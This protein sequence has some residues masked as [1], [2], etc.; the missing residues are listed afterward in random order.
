MKIDMNEEHFG[1]VLP[2]PPVHTAKQNVGGNENTSTYS[3]KQPVASTSTVS[4]E[5]PPT[6]KSTISPELPVTTNTN[7]NK[8][9]ATDDS[10]SDSDFIGDVSSDMDEEKKIQT[11]K[12]KTKPRTSYVNQ[13][14]LTVR[15]EMT[16]NGQSVNDVL[17][18]FS[19]FKDIS[20]KAA[21]YADYME[22]QFIKYMDMN[23]AEAMTGRHFGT[24]VPL[25]FEKLNKNIKGIKGRHSKTSS[26]VLKNPQMSKSKS[27][28]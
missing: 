21:R 22:T 10:D 25:N 13:D 3:A 27:D 26:S 9:K 28:K 24:K 12:K 6:A 8:R 4:P 5:P 16:R 15:D 14:G 2:D 18:N 19:Y 23:Y 1:V 7:G 17:H 11:A 20:I